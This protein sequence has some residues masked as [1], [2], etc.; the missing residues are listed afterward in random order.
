MSQ[1]TKDQI[2]QVRSWA[3]EGT[4]LGNIQKR[5]A[6][7]FEVRLTFMDTRFLLSD[8]NIEIF[9]EEEIEDS[10]EKSDEDVVEE[11]VSEGSTSISEDSQ[12]PPTT[13]SQVT[14][15]L[16]KIT[17]P[18]MMVSGKAT[19]SDNKTCGWYIDQTGSLGLNPS[20]PGYQPTEADLMAFQKELKA[21]IQKSGL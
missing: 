3:A 20:E 1:L 2:E 11:I 5:I 13:P 6:D 12:A 7:E 8:H 17:T 21:T 4:P 10:E 16:D 18:G 15:T 9:E 19:F 14:V